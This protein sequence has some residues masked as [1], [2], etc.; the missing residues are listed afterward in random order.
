MQMNVCEIFQI[1]WRNSQII[2]RTQKCLRP[3]TFL[4][5]VRRFYQTQGSTVF[6]LASRET[7]VAKYAWGPRWQGP[8]QTMQQRSRTSNRKVLLFVTADHKVLNEEGESRDSHRYAVVVQGLATQHI[9]SY[10]CRSKTSQETE[11]SL[12]KFVEPSQ[13]PKVNDTNNSLEFGKTSGDLPWNH[14]TSTPHRSERNGFAERAVWRVK[15]GTSAVL[16]QSGLEEKWWADSME[17][18]WKLPMKGDSENHSEHQWFRLEQ[19]SNTIRYQYEINQDFINLASKSYQAFSL[20]MHSSRVESGKEMLWLRPCKNCRQWTLQRF[21]L[22]GSTQKKSWLFR[23]DK[24]Q[25]PSS[26]WNSKIVWKLRIPG[27]HSKTGANRKECRTQWRSSR[28]IGRVST[29]RTKRWLVEARRDFFSFHGDFIHR[30]RRIQVY[31]PK[32][33]TFPIPL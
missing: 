22:E 19:W 32:E 18:Y 15:E 28:R 29:H 17:C 8:V 3:H 23:M 30:H 1:G 10:P 20:G 27:T 31:V 25:I 2:Q 12:R 5:P 7:E 13:K 33:E 24:N 9:Q 11:K 21:T 6:L 14:R 16:L 4:N 26:R